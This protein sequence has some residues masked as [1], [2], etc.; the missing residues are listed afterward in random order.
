M[1]CYNNKRIKPTLNN[2]SPVQR[3]GIQCHPVFIF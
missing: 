3:W 2:M 1:D